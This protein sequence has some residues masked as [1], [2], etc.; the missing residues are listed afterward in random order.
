MPNRSGHSTDHAAALFGLAEPGNIYTRLMNPTTDVVEQRIA[1]LEGGVA[2]LLLSSG[3]TVTIAHWALKEGKRA[4]LNWFLFF[5]TKEGISKR[6]PLSS[7]ANIRNNGLIAFDIEE[8]DGT[9]RGM[10]ALLLGIPGRY[11]CQTR[12]FLGWAI[13]LFQIDLAN[14]EKFHTL[15]AMVIVV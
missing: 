4:I 9:L 8:A 3:V 11:H 6:S 10:N 12:F 13:I 14:L 15:Q 1:S 5:T 2:A 7:F